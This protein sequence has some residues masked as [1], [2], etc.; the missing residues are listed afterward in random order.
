MNFLHNLTS[1]RAL[2]VWALVFVT[3]LCSPALSAATV[4]LSTS[5]GS[6]VSSFNSGLNWKDTDEAPSSTHD[7][8]VSYIT[9][10]TPVGSGDYTFVG[11]SLT[12]VG[13]ANPNAGIL[14]IAGTGLIT[15]NNLTLKGGAGASVRNFAGNNTTVR[16][17]GSISVP[18]L[19]AFGRSGGTNRGINVSATIGGEG[20]VS[21]DADTV[22]F[23]S[24]NSYTGGTWVVSSGH[25]VAAAAGALGT[26]D[27]TLEAGTKLTLEASAAIADTA[28]L[29]LD[30]GMIANSISL[31]FTG[32]EIVGALFFGNQQIAAGSYTVSELNKLLTDSY[33]ASASIFT[34]AGVLQVGGSI[35]EV[36]STALFFALPVFGIVLLCR[37]FF[38][39]VRR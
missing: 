16:L 9:L 20:K 2:F 33:G 21:V 11:Q 14:A 17:A 18:D 1:C 27:L 37:R 7:Y 15:I 12:V 19:A 25:L 30:T 22:T 32:T 4:T 13:G 28:S 35:P 34:G 3:K 38:L 6:G 39:G 24:A 5:D 31:S 36:S 29:F 10:R 8:Q 23:S 26:G